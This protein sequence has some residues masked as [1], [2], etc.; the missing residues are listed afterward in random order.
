MRWR[1]VIALAGAVMAFVA[2][3]IWLDPTVWIAL[4]VVGAYFIGAS[5]GYFLGAT[6]AIDAYRRRTG[7][8]MFPWESP[9]TSQEGAIAT[10][11]RMNRRLRDENARLRQGGQP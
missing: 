6:A 9:R 5:C 1:D 10:L 4:F 7:S 3:A 2:I 11:M 8:P